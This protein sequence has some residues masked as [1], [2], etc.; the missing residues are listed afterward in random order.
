MKEKDPDRVSY[1]FGMKINVGNYESKDF[2]VSLT[3][4]IRDGETTEK[5]LDRVRHEV[6]KYAQECHKRLSVKETTETREV[7]TAESKT[8][9]TK[10]KTSKPAETTKV[11]TTEQTEEITEVFSKL[12]DAN[13]IDAVVFKAKYLNGKRI[14]Q[15]TDE[16][17]NLAILGLKNDFPKYVNGGLNA[18]ENR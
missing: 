9:K 12:A 11:I 7:S 17:A 6:E 16:E 14:S 4:D 13:E 8:G 15:L 3:S 10:V 18:N 2:H 1:S 5:A